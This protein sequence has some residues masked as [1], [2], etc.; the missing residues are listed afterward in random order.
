MWRWLPIVAVLTWA[1]PGLGQ[2]TATT[3][4]TGTGTDTGADTGADADAARIPPKIGV[5]VAGDPDETLRNTAAFLETEATAAGLRVPSDPDL[6]GAMRGEPAVVADGLDGMRS[7]RRGLGLNPR[8]DLESYK[9]IGIIAGADALVVVHREGDFLI[10]VFDVSAAQFY[11]GGVR[12]GESST[13]ERV[14]FIRSRAEQAQ[15]RWAAPP[16]PPPVAAKKV[17]EP[18]KPADESRA[19]R[20]MKKA[21]PYVVAGVLLAAGVTY[22]IIDRRNTN[23]AEPPLLR[24]RPGEE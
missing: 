10:E 14:E 8:K 15:L 2:D 16:P 9:R 3:T 4:G 6:R 17:N 19:K 18:E 11:E 20:R 13:D 24:F 21:W 12:F 7:I 23:E 5:V 22:L 1:S